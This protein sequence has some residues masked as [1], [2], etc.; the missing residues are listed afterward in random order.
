VSGGAITAIAGPPGEEPVSFSGDGT[1]LFVSH[2]TGD[3]IEIDRITL[4]TRTRESWLRI[5][6]E[7]RPVF[8]SVALDA[9]GQQ[10]TYSSNSDASDLFVLTPP[11]AR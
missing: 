1:S 8:Y 3:T 10:I 6:P 7:Q 5:S 4:A 9:S 11:L 2:V